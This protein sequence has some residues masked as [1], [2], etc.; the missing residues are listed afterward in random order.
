MELITAPELAAWIADADRP[1]PLLLDVREPW[2]FDT[3]RL[4]DAISIPMNSVPSRLEELDP[5][6]PVV[7]ICHHGARS[8]QVATFLERQGFEKVTNLTGGV[9][10][11]AQ[12]VD[13]AMPTY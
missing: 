13:P 6:L 3:C 5:S 11:W 8:L 10:A 2:E 1:S 7:C 9:H 12:Q 4:T